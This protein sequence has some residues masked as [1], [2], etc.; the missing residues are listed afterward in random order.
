M[1]KGSE[2]QMDLVHLREDTEAMWLG[3]SERG[4]AVEK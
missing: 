2:V 1:C 4:E 3:E